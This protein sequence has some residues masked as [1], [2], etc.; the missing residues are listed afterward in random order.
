LAPRRGASGDNKVAERVVNQ[1][2]T[3][4]DGLEEL[5]NVVVIGATNRPDILDTALLRPGRFDRI[6]MVG[7]PDEKTRY[8][9][10]EIHTKNMPLAKNIDIKELATKTQGYAGADIAS[11][12]RE[13]AINALRKNMDAKEVTVKDFDDAIEKVRP[14][15][16]KDIEDSY[17]SLKDMFT[18]ARAKEMKEERPSYFM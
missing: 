11:I 5:H 14:S 9:I 12:C 4:I 3:E 17:K 16:T 8:R 13:A 1:L 18:K 6:I 7:A 2:L 15:I 10:F